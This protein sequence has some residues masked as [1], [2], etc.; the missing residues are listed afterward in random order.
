MQRNNVDVVGAAVVARGGPADHG[1]LRPAVG[2]AGHIG[3]PGAVHRDAAGDV[4]AAPSDI[5]DIF[6]LG[7]GASFQFTLPIAAETD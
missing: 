3:T 4:G 5:G 7:A 2:V 1:E 6:Q